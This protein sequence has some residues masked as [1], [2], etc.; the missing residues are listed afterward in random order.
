MRGSI[1]G[2]PSSSLDAPAIGRSPRDGQHLLLVTNHSIENFRPSW[3]RPFTAAVGP[4][5]CSFDGSNASWE[6]VTSSPSR[7]KES[8]SDLSWR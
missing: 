2:R 1:W 7:Q 3:F 4:L 5:N 6:P 8:H